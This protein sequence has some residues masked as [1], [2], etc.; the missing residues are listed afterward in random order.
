MTLPKMN[1][2]ENDPLAMALSKMTPPSM[3]LLENDPLAMALSKMTL[4]KITL[5]VMILQK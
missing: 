2:P 1:L 4:S 3:N 5:S